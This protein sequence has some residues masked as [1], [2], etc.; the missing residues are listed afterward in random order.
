MSG[1]SVPRGEL[2]QNQEVGVSFLDMRPSPIPL[3]PADAVPV[4]VHPQ[5]SVAVRVIDIGIEPVPMFW[6]GLVITNPWWR[7]Y[8]V[9]RPGLILEVE[10]EQLEYPMDGVMVIPGWCRYRF[11]A[12]PGVWH[13]YVHF[14]LPES[15]SVLT[16]RTFPRPFIL[17]RHPHLLQDLRDLAGHLSR[18]G[19]APQVRHLAAAC[20]HQAVVAAWDKF[21][22][23]TGTTQPQLQERLARVQRF[24]ARHLDQPL[25]IQSLA[26]HLE[27]S[28]DHCI[29]L[30]REAI[31]MTPLQYM[32]EQRIA[33]AASCLAQEDTS[34]DHIARQCGF[35]DRGHL[36]RTF[37]RRMGVTP[38]RYRRLNHRGGSTTV[39]SRRAGFTLIELLVVIAI[40]A[41][42]AGMLLPAIGL[43]REQ[44]KR[45]LCGGMLRQ[46]G[47]AL[48]GYATDNDNLVP[49]TA[50]PSAMGMRHMFIWA[51]QTAA[52]ADGRG[53]DLTFSVM[54]DYLD[55]R[56]T[57]NGGGSS[58][59]ISATCPAV[60][61]A[62]WT[63][64]SL[65]YDLG[66]AYF[67]QS[68]T[69]SQV[70]DTVGNPALGYNFLG[71]GQLESKRLIMMDK[72]MCLSFGDSGLRW[73]NHSKDRAFGTTSSYADGAV[74]Q[75]LLAGANLL[76]GDG[77]VAWFSGGTFNLP[78]KGTSPTTYQNHPGSSFLWQGVA[79]AFFPPSSRW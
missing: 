76:F 40:I 49:S 24:I 28:R 54:Q 37:G 2:D 78:P 14:E 56:N 51:T 68:Q 26:D 32:L 77:R 7:L 12:S 69:W 16:Q 55:M 8:I 9:D 6:H 58:A 25:T 4:V 30:F 21:P 18:S 19:D 45:V 65:Y 17:D 20:A 75:D 27:V 71:T 66:Y 1:A 67:G 10:G 34:I 44:S 29:R 41:I 11:L 73:L 50:R 39:R 46:W 61:V 57:W 53:G 63:G 3:I 23:G 43:V 22:P 52:V 64:S 13:G 74:P 48:R 5:A 33:R 42:L 59:Q 60:K 31:G 36:T 38:A 72:V 70:P 79:W 47:L 35:A 62:R 15:S